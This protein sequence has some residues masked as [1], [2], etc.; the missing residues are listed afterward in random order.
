M[1]TICSRCGT[2][3]H[4]KKNPTCYNCLRIENERKRF[5]QRGLSSPYVNKMPP[6]AAMSP[7]ALK[8]AVIPPKKPAEK[9]VIISRRKQRIALNEL[10]KDLY[11]STRYL[12]DILRE[13]QL[14]PSQISKLKQ[15]HLPQYLDKLIEEVLAF[16][17]KK[18]RW[19]EVEM[20]RTKYALDGKPVPQ[21]ESLMKQFD[22][23]WNQIDKFREAGLRRLRSGSYIAFF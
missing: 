17:K 21:K 9:V 16:W 1:T 10:L 18:L 23:S 2:T 14:S 19:Q 12:S 6:S 15:T 8:P 22:L 11:G 20:L 3:I 4:D 5:G 13:G 7:S